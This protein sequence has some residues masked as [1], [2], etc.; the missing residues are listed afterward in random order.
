MELTQLQVKKLREM[1]AGPATAETAES[2]VVTVKVASKRPELINIPISNKQRNSLLN[3]FGAAS[4]E[5][6]KE[7]ATVV[8]VLTLKPP[9]PIPMLFPVVD[10]RAAILMSD[11][12]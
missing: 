7:E 2:G 5:I 12:L 10:V 3:L 4:V 9:V 1:F 6:S 8:I 11:P